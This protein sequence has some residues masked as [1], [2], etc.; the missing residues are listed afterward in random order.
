MTKVDNIDISGFEVKKIPA[1][2]R[3]GQIKEQDTVSITD[4][5]KAVGWSRKA[6][7]DE[8]VSLGVLGR[9]D[10]GAASG[11]DRIVFNEDFA[12]NE[13]NGIMMFN[14]SRGTRQ[15]GEDTSETFTRKYSQARF[16]QAGM[17]IIKNV[18]SKK[19]GE[20]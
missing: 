4:A 17:E 19:E 7:I 16:T 8:L 11:Q 6:F 15:T 10:I 13:T 20:K 9:F 2:K 18:F 5:A 12:Q 1:F 14:V 3:P